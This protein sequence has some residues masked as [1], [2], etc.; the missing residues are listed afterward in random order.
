MKKIKFELIY[1]KKFPFIKLKRIKEKT[2]K[3]KILK[4]LFH[5][6]NIILIAVVVSWWTFYQDY[7]SDFIKNDRN[8][9][10]D[11]RKSILTIKL[12]SW[13]LIYT[14]NNKMFQG[15]IKQ[16][17]N[18]LNLKHIFQYNNMKSEIKICLFKSNKIML[19]NPSEIDADEY[20]GDFITAFKNFITWKASYVNWLAMKKFA[21]YK[22]WIKDKECDYAIFI[23]KFANKKTFYHEFWH[24]VDYYLSDNNNQYR[25]ARENIFKKKYFKESWKLDFVREYW[26]TNSYEDIATIVWSYVN[27]ENIENKTYLL[28]KKINFLKKYYFK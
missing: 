3:Q 6:F 25:Q 9:I 18:K 11:T 21:F 17:G 20:T 1:K 23:F 12:W 13:Q 15:W 7:Y 2:L 28:N 8:V 27:W 10:R 16:L 26:S 19:N 22:Y 4:S 24:I 14:W 5:I